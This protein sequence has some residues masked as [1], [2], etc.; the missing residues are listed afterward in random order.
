MTSDHGYLPR[1]V[2]LP[3]AEVRHCPRHSRYKSDS[4]VSPVS[5]FRV[6]C[7]FTSRNNSKHLL[8]AYRI[9]RKA[10]RWRILG[11]HEAQEHVVTAY[12]AAVGSFIPQADSAHQALVVTVGSVSA[13]VRW[14]R[15]D[16]N[17]L[18]ALECPEPS[19]VAT[20]K[21]LS[22]PDSSGVRF[23]CRAPHFHRGRE[24]TAA[25]VHSIINAML[26]D[27]DLSVFAECPREK[28][29]GPIVPVMVFDRSG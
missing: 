9:I 29:R 5:D 25:A 14:Q 12:G 4:S 28:R 6:A 1:L 3:D 15:R 18:N 19:F 23:P 21:R 16:E 11:E 20:S 24:A 7:I 10:F 8:H 22:Y 17:E 26:C 13:P 2:C 27:F